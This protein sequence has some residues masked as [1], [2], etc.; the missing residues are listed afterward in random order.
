MH[1]APPFPHIVELYPT[2]THLM[3][4]IIKHLPLKSNPEILEKPGISWSRSFVRFHGVGTKI[5]LTRSSEGNYRHIHFLFY[6]YK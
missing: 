5:P 1:L 6:S 4:F 3:P 2:F